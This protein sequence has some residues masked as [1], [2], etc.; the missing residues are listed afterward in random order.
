[1]LIRYPKDRGIPR[2][3]GTTDYIDFV[4]SSAERFAQI[5][6]DVELNWRKGATVT[7]PIFLS[8]LACGL[9]VLCYIAWRVNFPK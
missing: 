5:P 9:A 3:N 4:V 7:L 1:M 6:E 8:L 2:R